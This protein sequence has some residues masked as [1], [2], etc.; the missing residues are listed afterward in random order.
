MVLVMTNEKEH[1][2]IF[3]WDDGSYKMQ[4]LSTGEITDADK[5]TVYESETYNAQV[6]RSTK[7]AT[8]LTQLDVVQ[9]FFNLGWLFADPLHWM[10]GK[11]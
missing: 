7:T 9:T 8:Q 1:M 6:Y 2:R 5:V 4:D 3:I 11:F 10:E